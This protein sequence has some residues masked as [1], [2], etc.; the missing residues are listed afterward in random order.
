VFNAPW[1]PA[2]QIYTG[3]EPDFP[4]RAFIYIFEEGDASSMDLYKLCIEEDQA[5][6]NPH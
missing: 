1:L 4:D 5:C 3:D 2:G 6:S